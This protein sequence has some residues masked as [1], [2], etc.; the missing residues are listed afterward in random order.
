VRRLISSSRIEPPDAAPAESL[1]ADLARAFHVGP[2][3]LR[4]PQI[5]RWDERAWMPPLASDPLTFM[6]GFFSPETRVR[7][8]VAVPPKVPLATGLCGRRSSSRFTLG[9]EAEDALRNFIRSLE[10]P[11]PSP[12]LDLEPRTGDAPREFAT[13]GEWDQRVLRAVVHLDR[14]GKPR[15]PRPGRVTYAGEH[16]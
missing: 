14:H 2:A 13:G 5:F 9:E 10:E 15:Q 1:I 4:D 11:V 6:I 3:E 7:I 16:L 8:P 12:R